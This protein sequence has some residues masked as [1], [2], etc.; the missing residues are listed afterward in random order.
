MDRP[1]GTLRGLSAATSGKGTGRQAERS[2]ATRARLVK[3]ARELFTERPY[4]D[5][6][7]EEIVRRARV[8]RGA[9]YHHFADKRD[10]FR[11]VHEQMEAELVE[12]I[13]GQLAASAGGDPIEALRAGVRSYLDACADPSFARITLVDAPAVLGWEEWRRIDEEHALRLILAGLEGAMEAGALRRQPVRPLAQLMLGTMGEAGLV[14]ANA[15][16]PKATRVE[17]EAA[18]LAWLEGLRA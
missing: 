15:A 9:L 18:L 6:G 2:S 12:A 5:V 1:A 11:A 7:T 10:L 8:T 16:D 3:A 14:I 4:A 17:I 13:Q